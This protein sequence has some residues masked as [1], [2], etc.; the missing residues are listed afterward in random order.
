MTGSSALASAGALLAALLVGCASHAAKQPVGTVSKTFHAYRADGELSVQVADVSTGSCWTMS[1]AATSASAFR[2][3]SDNSILDPCFAPARPGRPLEVACIPDPWTGATV[4]R[5]SGAL[6]TGG[7]PA[8]R[9][10]HPWAIELANGARCVVATGTVPA[11]QGVNLGYHC[12]NGAN[13]ALADTT[14]QAG[15]G[16]YAKAKYALAGATT[17]L[18]VTVSTIWRV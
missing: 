7:P 1:I 15:K 5:V 13:A 12:R 17:L 18:T 10:P 9:T 3:I 2:C 14:G 11:V 16:Q 4:L 8:G 6:P